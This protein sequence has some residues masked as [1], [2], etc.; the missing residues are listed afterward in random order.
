MGSRTVGIRTLPFRT[1]SLAKRSPME[2]GTVL[3]AGKGDFER[4]A[5][6]CAASIRKETSGK[7]PTRF[8]SI[9]DSV[10]QLLLA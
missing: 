10:K 7:V 8:L 4:T 6:S 9:T 2:G 5:Q 1:H 3:R